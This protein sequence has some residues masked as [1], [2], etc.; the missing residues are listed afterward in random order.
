MD[1]KAAIGACAFL[2]M[3]CGAARAELATLEGRFIQ[4]GVVFGTTQPGARVTLNGRNVRVSDSG[5]FVFGFGRDAPSA[6]ELIVVLP[7][8]APEKRALRIEKRQYK[9]QRIDKLPKKM[10]TPPPEVL[11][12]IRMDREQ[13]KAARA[14]D[15]PEP[16]FLGSL[17]IR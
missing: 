11:E 16:M 7:G 9:I 13:V 6:A 5:H 4:G 2:L 15:R 3:L 14:L 10:V 12:R 1:I 17:S 8:G